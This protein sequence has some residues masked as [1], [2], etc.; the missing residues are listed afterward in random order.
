MLTEQRNPRTMHV[1]QLSSLEIVQIINDEDATVAGAVRQS[2]PQIAQ[3]VDT[4]VEGM[5]HGGRL[6]YIG[7]GTSGRLGVLDA[8][9]CVP[10]FSTDPAMV[11]GIVAGG[12]RAITQSIEGAEDNREAG[13]AAIRERRVTRHDTVV[14]IAASGHT[15]YVIG[16]LEEAN[17]RGAATVAVACNAPAPLFDVAQIAIPALVGPEVITGSTRLKAG[18]AQ[19]MVLNM[20]STAS[21]IR[22]GKVYGNLMV[23]LQVTCEKLRDRGERILMET[24]GVDRATATALLEKSGGHVKTAIVMGRLDVDA[25]TARTRLE[26]EGGLIGRLIPD[27]GAL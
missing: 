27:L 23:D 21:M 9:E 20:L 15:P 2:L 12:D 3:A 8:V 10:T 5:R 7:A 22:L 19:K 11:Q 26:A 6:L 18:T 1:D 25:R 16:A 14:G 13:R 4:I 17:A 24:I